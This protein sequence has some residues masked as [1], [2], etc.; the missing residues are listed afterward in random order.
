MP[1][2]GGG[3]RP[4]SPTSGGAPRRL[5]PAAVSHR[6]PY[7]SP[8]G[9]EHH[10]DG[11]N[12]GGHDGGHGHDHDGHHHHYGYYGV[13]GW[14]GYPWWPYYGWG[15]PYLSSYWPSYW[16]SSDNYDS[17]PA[18]NYAA[19]QYPEY[20]PGPYEETQPDQAPEQPQPEEPSYTP[21][22][23]SKPAPDVPQAAAAPS[24]AAPVTLVFKDG[25][26]NERIQN[27]LLTAKTLS[28]LDQHRREIP[29]DQIDLGATAMVNRDAG[30][31]FAVPD[32]DR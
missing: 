20:A 8:H 21:W 12:H 29:V 17:Q 5:N 9:G 27:Y 14:A 31:E 10:G 11:W 26:P 7:H 6:M 24:S 22:P 25:R 3:L 2:G 1:Y 15:Y 13:Y 4:A 16:Y 23:Y 28:V 18:S 30:V 32:A 19:S